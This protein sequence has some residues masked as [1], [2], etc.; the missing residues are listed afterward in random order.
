MDWLHDFESEPTGFYSEIGDDG[1]EVRKVQRYRDGR[2]LRADSSHETAEIGLSEIPVGH[3][4]DV[5]NQPEFAARLISR[6]EFEQA[7]NSAEWS[8]GKLT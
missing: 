1:Y 8:V 5:A 3:I 6:E 4:E 7:W 2:Q